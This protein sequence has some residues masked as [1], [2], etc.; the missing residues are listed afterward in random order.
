VTNLQPRP[1][2]DLGARTISA[3]VIVA[4]TVAAFTVGREVGQGVPTLAFVVLI[5]AA[6]IWEFWNLV[7]KITPNTVFRLGIMLLGTIY[8]GWATFTLIFVLGYFGN[9]WILI[10]GGV[11]ATDIG[12][13]FAGRA[14]GG[15]KIA[16]KISPSKTWAGLGG[17]VLAASL[18]LALYY[19]PSIDASDPNQ[20]VGGALFASFLLGLTLAVVAQAGDFFE[21]WLKRKAGVKDSSNL[22]PGHGGVFDRIDGLIA[23]LFVLG[24]MLS[25]PAGRLL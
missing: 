10:I 13:Y 16:P 12:A 8:F 6:L 18:V 24:F 9:A 3:I 17:G 21:S 5:F 20:T 11:A 15:P 22:I 25:S 7:R 1:K 23:V 2:S 19:V 4:V 14:I